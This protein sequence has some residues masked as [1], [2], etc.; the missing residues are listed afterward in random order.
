MIVMMQY[1]FFI[2]IKLFA[3]HFLN[4]GWFRF[5]SKIYKQGGR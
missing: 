5:Y 1:L 3:C 4:K 2:N